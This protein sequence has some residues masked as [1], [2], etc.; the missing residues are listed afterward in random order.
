M[1]ADDKVLVAVVNNLPD[2]DRVQNEGW[3]RLPAKNAPPGSPDYDW[4]G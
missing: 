4:L 1:Y 2:W 3:Y